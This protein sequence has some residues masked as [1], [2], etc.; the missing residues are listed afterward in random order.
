MAMTP[1]TETPSSQEGHNK[2]GDGMK[3]FGWTL[4]AI[5][6]L[7]LLIAIFGMDT[8]VASST[9]YGPDRVNNLGMMQTQNQV[10]MS[11]LAGILVG[12]V[13]YVGGAIVGAL[14]AR[15]NPSKE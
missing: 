2:P 4:M 6:I 15:P 14:S 8:S 13:L 11:G 9:I 5:S 1:S 3:I 10:F 12:I 7:A